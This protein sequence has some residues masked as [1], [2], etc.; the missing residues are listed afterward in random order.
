LCGVISAVTEFVV[1]ASALR[2][3]LHAGAAVTELIVAAVEL[4]V[5]VGWQN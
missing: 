1:R 5:R 4:V 2:T 3:A